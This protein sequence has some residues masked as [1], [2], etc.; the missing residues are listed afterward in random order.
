MVRPWYV[1]ALDQHR[2][3]KTDEVPKFLNIDITVAQIGDV[4]F[5]GL[6]FEPFVRT[7]LKVKRET[8]LPCVLTCGYVGETSGRSHGYIPDASA[9]EDREYQAG[10]FRY[11]KGRPPYRPPAG[12]RTAEVAVVKLT[13]YAKQ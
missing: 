7:G 10:F 8:P 9:T 12:D 6:P 1:W 5:V 11:I 4:G 13:E 3:G 2:A